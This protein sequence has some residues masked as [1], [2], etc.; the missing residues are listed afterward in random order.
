L[1][2]VSLYL[3][4]R[5]YQFLNFDDDKYITEDANVARG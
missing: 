2:T 5:H 4:A 1:V 3:P